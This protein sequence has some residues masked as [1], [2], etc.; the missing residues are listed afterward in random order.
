MGEWDVISEED[1]IDDDPYA[2][3]SESTPEEFA[4]AQ[5]PEAS[6]GD[7][8]LSKAKQ[9]VP[10]AKSVL[11]GLTRK[12]GEFQP[13]RSAYDL[14]RGVFQLTGPA[15]AQVVAKSGDIEDAK[16]ID[17][18]FGADFTQKGIDVYR[19]GQQE[20]QAMEPK[21]TPGTLKRYVGDVVGAT[22][23]MV[24]A[25]L[26]GAVTRN[27]NTA[28]A[29]MFPQV[30]GMEYAAARERGLT[31]DQANLEGVVLASSEILTEKLPFD[32]LW[33]KGG[34]K[35]LIKI[36]KVAGL[37]GAQ[38]SVQSAVEQLVETGVLHDKMTMGEAFGIFNNPETW[39]K[40]GYAGLVG[41]GMGVTIA[42]PGA[43]VE[44]VAG[45]KAPP[46]GGEPVT[47]APTA[48]E[49]GEWD[50]VDE[51]L[52]PGEEVAA[53][54]PVPAQEG[55]TGETVDYVAPK[56]AAEAAPE[57]PPVEL[58]T[59]PGAQ[60]AP[61]AGEGVDYTP[62]P[63]IPD[64][65]VETEEQAA[66]RIETDRQLAVQA[67]A[68][69]DQDIE[70]NRRVGD[71]NRATE[72]VTLPKGFDD[73]RL[74]RLDYRGELEKMTADLTVG[75][76]QGL[77]PA[78]DFVPGEA[79]KRGPEAVPQ[80]RLPSV[81]PQ[82]FQ[83][84][85]AQPETKVT[86]EGVGRIV[87]KAL[88]GKTLGAKEAR[89]MEVL[90]DQ[91]SEQRGAPE[92]IDFAQDELD[93]ARNAR[94]EIQNQFEPEL[95]DVSDLA[96][97]HPEIAYAGQLYEEG[98]YEAG[99]DLTLRMV[100]ESAEQAREN[101]A[102]YDELFEILDSRGSDS[103]VL[104][105][106]V[107][108]NKE[109][110]DGRKTE[111]LPESRAAVSDKKA[112]AKRPAKPVAEEAPA[113]EKQVKPEKVEAKVEKKP[114]EKPPVKGLV[115]ANIGANGRIYYGET[116]DLHFNLSERYPHSERGDWQKVGFAGPDGRVLN[117]SE[118]LSWMREQGM[119]IKPSKNMLDELDAVDMAE[120]LKT[121]AAKPE[122]KPTKK[123]AVSKI[124][125]PDLRDTPGYKERRAAIVKGI[126]DLINKMAPGV[127][128][129]V[130]DKVFA[131]GEGLIAS[132]LEAVEAQEIA[133]IHD[134]VENLIDVSLNRG[135]PTSTAH[136]E[137]MHALKEAGLFT[138]REWNLLLDQAK[139]KWNKKYG[140]PDSEEG[141][142]YAFGDWRLEKGN[143]D[144]AV[145]NL[146]KRIEKF[147]ERL[148]NFVRGMGFNTLDDIFY[149]IRTGVV[150]KRVPKEDRVKSTEK[151]FSVE[152][153]QRGA[154]VIDG[155]VED[156]IQ[157]EKTLH[158][159]WVDSAKRVVRQIEDR[160]H[161][162]ST[163]EDRREFLLDRYLTQGRIANVQETAREI[164]ET[165]KSA[166]EADQRAVYDFLTD[167]KNDG[168]KI[169]SEK[170][171]GKAVKVKSFI[172]RIGQSLVEH[173][174]IPKESYENYENRYLP[175][176]YL[177]YLLGD[178]A[179]AQAGSG[180]S[181]S[182]KGYSKK[183]DEELPQEY[184]DVILGE[185]KDAAFL[186]S[187]AIGI[188]LRDIALMDWFARI[189]D[190][191]KWAMKNQMVKWIPPGRDK[192][193]KVT[194]FWLKYEATKLR[195]RA[196]HYTNP[197]LRKKALAE[198]ARM[199]E[200]A[201]KKLAEIGLDTGDV[202]KGFKQMPNSAKYGGLRG[203]VVRTE[204]Y[205][206]VVGAGLSVNPDAHFWE[207][208]FNYGGIG[209]KVTQWWK[210][211]LALDTPLPTPAGWTTMGEVQV[212][213]QLFDERGQ[214]CKVLEVKK[215]LHGRPCFEVAFSDGTK[216]IA[217]KDHRWFVI[218]SDRDEK[219][220]TTEEIKN[221][222]TT[223]PRG[224]RRHSIPV[225]EALELPTINLP[226]PP[227][228]LGAFLGDGCSGS[229]RICA[230]KEDADEMIRNL[231]RSGVRCSKGTVRQDGLRVFSIQKA[232]TNCLRN[233]D[234]SEVRP[235]RKGCKVCEQERKRNELSPITNSGIPALM[236]ELG[237][238]NDKHIPSL[239]LRASKDQRMEL[240]RGLMDT[241]GWAEK[242]RCSY[243][244]SS[245]RLRDGVVELIRSL[246]YKPSV[247]EHLPTCN[248]K[249]GK[250][251]WK[252]Q[253][254]A[255][256]DLP[257]F[258]LKRK[259]K[260]LAPAPKTRQ[261]SRTRQI[262][263]VTPVPSVPVRCIGVSSSSELFLAGHGFIPTHNSKVAA[264]PPAQVRNVVS[265]LI[266]LHLSGVP[267][268]RI[269][270]LIRR[271]I[272]ELRTKGK[273]YKIAVKHGFTSSTFSAQEM[274]RID[275]EMLDLHRRAEGGLGLPHL[276]QIGAEI[277]NWTGD[278]Y[279]DAEMMGK[280]IKIIYEMETNNMPE[281]DA[282]LEAQEWLFDYSLVGKRTRFLRNAPIG[283]PFLTFYLKV[284]PRLLEVATTKPWRF[285]PYAALMY[286]MPAL[287]GAF[288]GADDDE[289]EKL[290]KTL[291]QWLQDRG[292]A[293]F[294]PGRD[295]HGRWRAVDI[296]YFLPW[297]MW[298]DIGGSI[299]GVTEG[300]I[301][302]K[303]TDSLGDIFRM[304]GLFTGPLPNIIAAVTTGRDAFTGKE[305]IHEEDPGGEQLA[306]SLT[307][308]YGMFA[309][310]WLTGMWPF[311]EHA[312]TKGATGHLY[313]AVT[314][315]VNR[316]GDPKSTVGQALARFVGVNI[317][318]IEP[319][320]SRT[321][322]LQFRAL[323]IKRVEARMK[324][325]LSDQNLSAEDRK[326][327]QEDY[328]GKI[329]RMV[330][331]AK[332]YAEESK[333]PKLLR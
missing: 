84:M 56:T 30:F 197:D 46:E 83:D 225:A 216:I 87:D 278:R 333:I 273:Y 178:K 153:E 184:R 80:V 14:A 71:I 19:A 277:V 266:L 102:D 253:Y 158:G 175:R 229:A 105:D 188:P 218:N 72:D 300:A 249:Q 274:I 231:V 11:G 152:E 98:E 168:L 332:K 164:Y 195:Q 205:D 85:A 192:A 208:L 238:F 55:Y 122:K 327:I 299:Y 236:R 154:D 31:P 267:M 174:V 148:A 293:L 264:N 99:L 204:I 51:V 284:L 215:V 106:L 331:E 45:R 171:R 60:P 35:L 219:I 156:I 287:V 68:K 283:A 42:A 322:N 63:Q 15:A 223:G 139:K 303:G 1:A 124:K 6:F 167:A 183:R 82:W 241:D 292:H 75:G 182:K 239:Y 64:L 166:T 39:K 245:A 77:A 38:E 120:Q 61:A 17:Q 150:G 317:Y 201:D 110:K 146:F 258:H 199:D 207:S 250:V 306:A 255:Y 44:A 172:N 210:W 282:I 133:G 316:Y 114:E 298:T 312:L 326:E 177:S 313:E 91:I 132:G 142:A 54:A 243:G 308:M 311:N 290:Q 20:M 296:G 116:G 202:P 111:E 2:V 7:V 22:A 320:K 121:E 309:P 57:A 163:L 289:M 95:A 285:L 261:R 96:D 260:R 86:V 328:V 18:I 81:N 304:T 149:N 165:F 281:S 270:G 13:E 5:T 21:T 230:G 228:A 108:Y 48:P 49:G 140:V 294:L 147:F 138:V 104:R 123:P 135:N 161:P 145:V 252:I 47:P 214:T 78:P 155:A 66:A 97:I 237:I 314:G 286:G 32:A 58:T 134:P 92:T 67:R 198:A 232:S 29:V 23:I 271:A 113:A 242:N 288:S 234:P 118:T 259:R 157:D 206:D 8:I 3:V 26:A 62:E 307:Y 137:A 94:R 222:L 176:L 256:S 127:D 190:N 220:L 128:V 173:G 160:L 52:A 189:A 276:Q 12:L 233:H 213:D 297:T 10:A 28:L 65:P 144:G 25:L 244:T 315:R 209:T 251:A 4:A 9:V 330:K 136:H 268:Y 33:K 227:F 119:P 27:P 69:A 200:L 291:P 70:R 141:I 130:S 295:E 170:I 100:Q 275:R 203:L 162:L 131:E 50:V 272:K 325:R 107:A 36:L 126:T 90:L 191:P 263:S 40:M 279:Q 129:K 37:E 301:T 265:N 247:V 93:Q 257:V 79:D 224:D 109:L 53:E 115:V 319:E 246:G 211:P 88:T 181:I 76:G 310:P 305:I 117:R 254:V 318:P 151:R 74:K 302:G 187:K 101:G 179:I 186:A 194:P 89:V 324:K 43:A 180:K 169:K 240:L 41:A 34:K 323:E 269:P 212:G 159:R 280:L 321:F 16:T 221:T 185:L 196:D 226:I 59:T 262:V 103:D 217:D 193:R 143:F 235:N 24:P 112:E 248:G 329:K 73:A 125:Q